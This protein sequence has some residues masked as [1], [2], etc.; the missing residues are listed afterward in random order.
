LLVLSLK[1]LKMGRGYSEAK[2]LQACQQPLLRHDNKEAAPW[3]EARNMLV[4]DNDDKAPLA[5]EG[6]EQQD[7]LRLACRPQVAEGVEQRDRLRDLFR[8]QVAEDVEYEHPVLIDADKTIV[9]ILRLAGFRGPAWEY[10]ADALVRYGFSVMKCWLVTGRIFVLCQERRFGLERPVREDWVRADLDGFAA[11]GVARGLNRFK[12]A[13]QN[14]AW[15]PGGGAT[16]RTFFMGACILEFPNLYR[17]CWL[18]ADSRWSE[19]AR[20]EPDIVTLEPDI[21]TWSIPPPDPGEVASMRIGIQ[22]ALRNIAD[23]AT[24]AAVIL[25]SEGYSYREIGEFLGVTPRAVDGL[26]RRHRKQWGNKSW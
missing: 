11:E 16:L 24:R 9:E 21:V 18:N 1:I 25:Q 13:L 3:F 15:D 4:A 5:A 12:R 2:R 7:I 8:P 19:L 20:L 26:L 6:G 10:Y 14:G 23:D 22:K 17:K